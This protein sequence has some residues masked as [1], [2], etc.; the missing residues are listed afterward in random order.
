M[1]YLTNMNRKVI[2]V[3]VQS[4]FQPFQLGITLACF[5]ACFV[6]K[7][8]RYSGHVCIQ[9]FNSHGKGVTFDLMSNNTQCFIALIKHQASHLS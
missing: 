5:L 7:Y 9:L 8:G 6:N 4:V 2:T 3:Q 1:I